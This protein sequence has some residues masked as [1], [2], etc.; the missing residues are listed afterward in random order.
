MGITR[1]RENVFSLS[2]VV[3]LIMIMVFHRTQHTGT[4]SLEMSRPL[5]PLPTVDYH[6]KETIPHVI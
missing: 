5:K 2:R 4:F 6:W 1:D 3:L